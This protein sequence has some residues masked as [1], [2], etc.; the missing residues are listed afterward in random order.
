MEALMSDEAKLL[1]IGEVAKL[2]DV[3]VETT[4]YCEREGLIPAPIRKSAVHHT[5]YRLYDGKAIS[6]L[7][8][9]LKAKTL[10][11]TLK[12]ISGLLNLKTDQV[13]SRSEVR[14]RAKDH[15]QDVEKRL[16]DMERIRRSL[17]HLIDEC[18]HGN[19]ESACL[20]LEFLD[21]RS[22]SVPSSQHK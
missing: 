13:S 10:G 11:F 21:E 18:E 8:L 19:Q 16:H 4:R 20:I 9:I 1:R 14:Q 5:G 6:R 2:L 15:L 3:G 17:L 12:E 7:R 22:E